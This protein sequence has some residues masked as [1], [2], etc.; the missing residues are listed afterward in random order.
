MYGGELSRLSRIYT[1]V[2]RYIFI[3]HGFRMTSQAAIRFH[4][5]RFADSKLA[6][7]QAARHISV[8]KGGNGTVP[9]YTKD[10]GLGLDVTLLPSCQ[11][12]GLFLYLLSLK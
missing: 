2:M 9:P 11:R 3:M 12:V 6:F 4:A 7:Q 5:V 1:Y 10:C 8:L